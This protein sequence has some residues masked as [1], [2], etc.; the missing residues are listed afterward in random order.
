MKSLPP[1]QIGKI[2]KMGIYQQHFSVTAM[3]PTLWLDAADELS[4][5]H[6]EGNVF[7]WKDKSG[8]GKH[9]TQAEGSR[10]LLTNSQTINGWNVLTADGIN[11][12][13]LGEHIDGLYDGLTAFIITRSKCSEKAS[14]FGF[15]LAVNGAGWLSPAE[16]AP[17]LNFT[18]NP[19]W[20]VGSTAYTDAGAGEVPTLFS[21]TSNGSNV[22]YYRNGLHVNS[23]T[24]STPAEEGIT[25]SYVGGTG[26]DNFYKGDIAEI[27]VFDRVLSTLQSNRLGRYLS[28]K[29][30]ITWINT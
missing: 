12:R 30:E 23:Q 28:N 2:G 6:N 16:N 19:N 26:G 8:N 3:S 9:F 21:C 20:Q 24:M 18:S 17:A 7:R 27:I 29:W 13:L 10:Q 25:A 22:S 1:I 11:D 15:V 14:G 4:I 5:E